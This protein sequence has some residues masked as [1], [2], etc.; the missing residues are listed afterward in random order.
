MDEVGRP[1][2]SGHDSPPRCGRYRSR[3]IGLPRVLP[4]PGVVVVMPIVA[5]HGARVPWGRSSWR[6]YRW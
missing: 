5:V 4:D 3:P 2:R 6:V 1:H